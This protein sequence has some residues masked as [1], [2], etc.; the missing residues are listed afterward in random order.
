M[1]LPNINTQ[2]D[3]HAIDA[4]MAN[5]LDKIDDTLV[6]VFDVLQDM[7]KLDQRIVVAVE[8]ML[9]ID[10]EQFDADQLS[11]G[12][13]LEA[14]REA[15]DKITGDNGGLLGK[16]IDETKEAGNTIAL[17][18]GALAAAFVA[19]SDEIPMWMRKLMGYQ[20]GLQEN[21]KRITKDLEQ[22][23]EENKDASTRLGEGQRERAK[24]ALQIMEDNPKV[25]GSGA[26]AAAANEAGGFAGTGEVTEEDLYPDQTFDANNQAEAKDKITE[27]SKEIYYL[28][29]VAT[30]EEDPEAYG[31]NQFIADKKLEEAIDIS[32]KNGLAMTADE[33]IKLGQPNDSAKKEN[34]I[35]ATGFNTISVDKTP[36]AAKTAPKANTVTPTKEIIPQTLNS[37]KIEKPLS[38]APERNTDPYT[39][40]V[41]VTSDEAFEKEQKSFT[42]R[43]GGT[44][45]MSDVL[46]KV[47]VKKS[48]SGDNENVVIPITYKSQEQQDSAKGVTVN[49]VDNSTTTNVV[50]GGGG[51]STG[52]SV[53]SSA[54][55]NRAPFT[56]GH[57]KLTPNTID[58]F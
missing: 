54:N 5:E 9:K 18:L 7:A 45:E 13:E 56:N 3:I 6:S 33:I 23:I 40:T 20:E 24:R 17:I 41:D 46:K 42:D 1:A 47:D 52:R 30:E 15:K 55:E 36:E 39:R 37:K 21:R 57:T 48:L 31:M 32:R 19:F 58:L 14:E 26:M 25:S 11:R 2:S 8:G 28:Q 38:I 4:M 44:E 10:Q 35:N 16:V 22:T 29:N 34:S 53:P 27:L 50:N 51:K 43:F 49:N 12:T